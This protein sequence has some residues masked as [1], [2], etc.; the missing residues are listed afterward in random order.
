MSAIL[1]FTII[2]NFIA[3]SLRIFHRKHVICNVTGLGRTGNSRF[4]MKLYQ[5]MLRAA[6]WTFLQNKYDNQ[7]LKLKNSF[8]ILPGSGINLQ[9][10]TLRDYKRVSGS[11][12]NILFASRLL[13]Q[14]GV[15]DYIAVAA[16]KKEDSKM[17]FFIAGAVAENENLG[18]S[19]ES[20][21]HKCENTGISYL[22]F[23]TDMPSLF[24]KMDVLIFPS[25]YNEGVPRIL[26]EALASGIIV[27]SYS[28]PGT[29]DLLQNYPLKTELNEYM[30][31]VAV[32][33]RV[34]SL[35]PTEKE[36]ISRVGREIVEKD[37]SVE[38]VINE[39]NIQLTKV[40]KKCGQT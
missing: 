10:F 13:Y 14:K 25:S 30:S 36:H 9:G 1:T 19:L 38:K 33:E 16:E 35:T 4:I 28:I 29:K 39:Y 24:H 2:P 37:Y 23:I 32:L 27:I 20:L 22:G 5:T 17:K 6:S 21:E 31:L 15:L 12:L 18:P 11:H 26:L 34:L 40:L 8:S 3:T 7:K